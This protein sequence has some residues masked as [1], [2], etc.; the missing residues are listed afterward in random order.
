MSPSIGAFACTRPQAGSSDRTLKTEVGKVY[1]L[2]QSLL[3]VDRCSARPQS[4]GV[5]VSQAGPGQRSGQVKKSRR[6]LHPRKLVAKVGEGKTI[7]KYQKGEIIFSQ[8][9]VAD[10]VFY[11]QRGKLKLTV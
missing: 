8:G 5:A 6:S 7:D 11:I 10:A 3:Q 9:D 1:T 2:S 4:G